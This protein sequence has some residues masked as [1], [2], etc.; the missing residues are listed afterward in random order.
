MSAQRGF[1]S[2]DQ[3]RPDPYTQSR[4][5]ER[6]LNAAI[7]Q[8]DISRSYEEYLDIFDEFYADDIEGSS[9]TTEEPNRGKAGVR[10]L[11]FGFLVP[12]HAMVEVGWYVNIRSTNVDSWRCCRRDP[13]CVDAGVGRGDRQGLHCEL[14]HLQ[15]MEGLACSAGASLRPPAKR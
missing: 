11:V 9:D 10:S 8:A 1:I 2:A 4:I 5:A 12:L 7:V 15:E 14:A 6:T 3:F 13:F